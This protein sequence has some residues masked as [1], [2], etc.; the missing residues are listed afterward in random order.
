M[1]YALRK[2]HRDST[3]AKIVAVIT[4][5]FLFWVILTNRSPA[6]MTGPFVEGPNVFSELAS[7]R[8][9]P[10]AE[11]SELVKQR[12]MRIIIANMVGDVN[13]VIWNNASGDVLVS[14][15]FPSDKACVMDI[16]ENSSF[17]KEFF[18]PEQKE[19]KAN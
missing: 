6:Q 16:L 5:G 10:H 8:C 13:K 15:I 17:S 19:E 7:V 12:G 2:G 1:K 14:D 18:W 11:F 4:I 9:M 3:A